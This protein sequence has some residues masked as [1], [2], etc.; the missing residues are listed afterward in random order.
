MGA[1]H[2]HTRSDRDEFI[3]VNWQNIQS[4]A[5]GNFEKYT[6]S[7]SGTDEGPY[8]LRSV[9]HYASTAFAVDPQEPTI[10][11]K[12]N[13]KAITLNVALSARDICHMKKHYF[14]ETTC[15]TSSMCT[16]TFEGNDTRESA[17]DLTRENGNIQTIQLC[18][19]DVSSS[20]T[21][22]FR[23]FVPAGKAVHV[24]AEVDFATFGVFAGESK[25]VYGGLFDWQLIDRP[26]TKE[27]TEDGVVYVTVSGSDQRYRLKLAW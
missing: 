22:W 26:F 23:V 17:V 3:T 25:V 5:R 16:P 13:G 20:D 14:P 21:D 6:F 15:E 24:T 18:R 4:G 1:F 7:F 27:M 9:M 12:Q 19:S 8:D 11:Q 10:V 2:E